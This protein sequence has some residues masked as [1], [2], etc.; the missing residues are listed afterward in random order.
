MTHQSVFQLDRADPLPTR[1]DDVLQTVDQL[2]I[3]FLVDHG[4]IPGAEPAI[5]E[6]VRALAP[7]VGVGDP[8]AA[9]QEFTHRLPVPRGFRA[10]EGQHFGF[11]ERRGHP[12][13]EQQFVPLF[14]R[15]VGQ[16]DVRLET[17]QDLA[18][19]P[20][21]DH[22]HTERLPAANQRFRCRAPTQD[23]PELRRERPSPR[24]VLDEVRRIVPNGRDAGHEG[25][26][27]VGEHVQEVSRL[28]VR[29]RQ[30]Q[31]GP[32]D[33]SGVGERPTRH[34]EHRDREND[35]VLLAH[36][37]GDRRGQSQRCQCE[38]R[39]HVQHTLRLP[40]RP[41]RIK[42][43]SRRVPMHI[44][45]RSFVWFVLLDQLRIGEC[46][47]YLGCVADDDDLPEGS[48]ITELLVERNQRVLDDQNF[49]LGMVSDVGEVVRVQTQVQRVD[50]R[51]DVRNR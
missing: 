44:H 3:P 47:R 42:K 51:A 43:E 20:A 5:D 27:L 17:E 33:Q 11:D 30:H 24:I 4:D 38:L 16:L 50:H 34:M 13:L 8:G 18:H 2:D 31:L 39:M 14:R 46:P 22:R 48:A 12:L 23:Q 15:K 28:R 1:F 32:D 10:I 25:P 9:H 37:V 49:V 36:V 6:R 19:P 26:L 7:I 21:V 35:G 29:A 45:Q 41:R 40:R